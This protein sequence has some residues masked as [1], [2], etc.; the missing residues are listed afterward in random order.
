[1]KI[2]R[3]PGLTEW[4]GEVIQTSGRLAGICDGTFDITCAPLTSL[5]RYYSGIPEIPPEEEIDKSIALVDYRSLEID[6][7]SHTGRLSRIG[8][9]VDLGGVGKGYTA[10]VVAWI[11]KG[12]GVESAYINM[13]GNVMVLGNKPDGGC[14][15]IGIQHPRGRRGV[16]VCVL[17]VSNKS[18]V[19][20]GDYE[21]CFSLNG[22]MYH[23]ILDPQ[24][25][26]PTDSGLVSTTVVCDCSTT[27][28]I[29]ST[30]TFVLGLE[31]GM[32]LIG[33]M[34]DV[35]A[36]FIDK[37]KRI[38]IT[39]GLRDCLGLTEEADGYSCFVYK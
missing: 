28:D 12:L 30:A 32:D 13:G 31:K 36:V 1:M 39:E 35:E 3:Y 15:L 2:A 20:S 23:H 17:P 33:G 7:E 38:Y 16:P 25:G 18:V 4:P 22:R 19:T 26:Y 34:T 29:F 37:N 6:S 14:W 5:W 21:K 9:A 24:T 11:Y 10:D 27:A 8:Q